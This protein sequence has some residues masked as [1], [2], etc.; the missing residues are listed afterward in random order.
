MGTSTLPPELTAMFREELRETVHM[1]STALRELEA[2]AEADRATALC[3]DVKRGFHNIKGTAGSMGMQDV[4]RLAHAAETFLA[5]EESRGS[6]SSHTLAGLFQATA[7]L[8][9]AAEG[10]APEPSKLMSLLGDSLPPPPM[11]PAIIEPTSSATMDS[12]GVD[13]R[14]RADGSTPGGPKGGEDVMRVSAALLEKVLSPLTS[15]VVA[16]T[17]NR[18]RTDRLQQM[19][20]L[21]AGLAQRASASLL[22]PDDAAQLRTLATDLDRETGRLRQDSRRMDQALSTLEDHIHG[23]RLVSMASL[24]SPLGLAIRDAALRTDKKVLLSFSATGIQ[25]DRRVLQALRSPLIHLVRNAVDHGIES[26]AARTSAGKAAE[27]LISIVVRSRGE[28]IEV[29]VE[30]DGGGVDVEQVKRHAIA[31]GLLSGDK[32]EALDLEEVLELL[33]RPGF[34][35][36]TSVSQ[37]SGRGIGLDVVHKVVR[38][39]GGSITLGS[40]PGRF[41]C[42]TITVPVSMVTTRVLFVRADG[43][44]FALP[45][46]GVVGTAHAAAP[47]FFTLDNKPFVKVA[48]EPALVRRLASASSELPK[49][50]GKVCVVGVAAAK[51]KVA[52]LVD[53]VLGEDEVVVR[54]LG[55]PIRHVPGVVGTTIAESGAVVLV[56]SPAEILELGVS[57]GPPEKKKRRSQRTILVVDDSITTRTLERHILERAGYAV[58]LASDGQE[59]LGV[60]RTGRF[61]LVVADVD[62]PRLDGISM[63][64]AMRA[65]AALESLP[66]ILVTSRNEESDRQR[67]LAAGAQAYI[68]KGRFDQDLL[69]QTIGRLLG[70]R[71]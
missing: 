5:Y 38:E 35:T 8:Q 49:L 4:A 16:R 46:G 7:W 28:N 6:V 69:L 43:R 48:G 56:V 57:A 24:E 42:F 39:L 29:A 58:R 33:A 52:L 31:R 30:D 21:A 67:G 41:T 63:V 68:V 27:G 70:D 65:D 1:I 34:S 61:D 2:G 51:G 17:E 59:A 20:E 23:M 11:V 47:D 22:D 45:L 15:L 3:H 66:A 32:V 60:M 50:D 12:R 53:E 14:T 10:Q 18:F 40:A 19:S 64:R 55:P 62:M 54:P 44:M 26:P 36:R 9:D 71:E 25:V 37:L 13:S